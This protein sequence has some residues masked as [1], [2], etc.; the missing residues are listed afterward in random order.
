MRNG[1]LTVVHLGPRCGHEGALWPHPLLEMVCEHQQQQP[2]CPPF[3][4]RACLPPHGLA[5]ALRWKE[6]RPPSQSDPPPHSQ[7]SSHFPEKFH[8]PACHLPSQ[9]PSLACS[10]SA[11]FRP[12]LSSSR[13]SC[14]PSYPS[15]P[16][17]SSCPW[18]SS[19]FPFAPFHPLR[20]Q[21]KRRTSLR[22]SCC[23]MIPLSSCSCSCSSS[24]L[25]CSRKRTWVSLS[26]QQHLPWF[27]NLWCVTKGGVRAGR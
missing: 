24:P 3:R 14:H 23:L 8:L 22:N 15:C 6:C 10:P 27:Q 11:A 18:S 21:M 19:C 9:Q 13:P 26:L 12:S 1:L 16:S 7:A 4:A 20:S 17:I 5:P 2:S 25:S